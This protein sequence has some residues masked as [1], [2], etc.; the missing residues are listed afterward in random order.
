MTEARG[1]VDWQAAY[2]RLEETRR[3]LEAGGALP[4]EEI[5]RILRA[6]AAAL[7][8][9]IEEAPTPT[10]L[11][12]LLVFSLAQERYAIETSHVLEVIPLRDLTPV[13][14]TPPFVLGVVNHRGRI[15][16]VLDLRGLL[17]LGCQ[18]APEGSRV[19]VV[20]AGGMT[21]GVLADAVSE[22]VRVG[23]PELAPPAA[24]LTGGRQT[25]LRGVTGEMV[26]VLDLEGLARDRRI[27]VDDETV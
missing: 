22:S 13:P 26:A 15:L 4:P 10:D 25:F 14:C 1:P 21:F 20:E 2:A 19:I 24:T 3:A 27:V 23:S 5:E 11:L 16:P 7:A 8:K 12:D 18:G 9:P 17:D 6:R